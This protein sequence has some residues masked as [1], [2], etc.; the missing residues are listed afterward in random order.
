M[1]NITAITPSLAS[2]ADAKGVFPP[3]MRAMT[4]VGF[5]LALI[6]A[7]IAP[8]AG[9]AARPTNNA[10]LIAEVD[11]IA[12]HWA[13]VIRPTYLNEETRAAL[14]TVTGLIPT[15]KESITA[16]DRSRLFRNTQA[17]LKS[18]LTAGVLVDKSAFGLQHPADTDA[19]TTL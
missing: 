18:V 6:S 1:P 19:G 7:E 2:G 3:M 8:D 13:L 12:Q 14:R 5:M 17:F 15:L 4:H 10:E 9:T 16:D 11:H